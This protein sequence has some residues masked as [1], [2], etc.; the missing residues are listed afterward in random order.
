MED[1]DPVNLVQLS[2]AV[3]ELKRRDY[4]HRHLEL[5]VRTE[6][7]YLKGV[8]RGEREG[9]LQVSLLLAPGL[10]LTVVT[11]D[12]LLPS[13]VEARVEMKRNVVSSQEVYCKHLGVGLDVASDG[14]HHLVIDASG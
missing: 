6:D 10:P 9:A 7:L 8:T 2:D 12:H 3:F 5:V 11:N 4:V 13:V 14:H 1:V